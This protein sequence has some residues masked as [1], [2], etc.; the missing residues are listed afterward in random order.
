M[1]VLDTHVWLWWLSN[2]E[3]LS[4]AAAEAIDQAIARQSINIS[5]ISAWE[6]A[7]LV[8]K[9]RLTL[10][11]EVQDWIMKAE[12]LPFLHFIPVNNAIAVKS[13][14]LADP[15]HQDPADRI[16]AATA[17]VNNAALITRD[18]KLLGYPPLTTI[19]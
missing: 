6:I 18:E 17:M 8:K 5:S 15:L 11:L 16:I 13:V 4:S 19:W 9:G 12:S 1:I 2:P 3:F 7:I 10:A 14:L